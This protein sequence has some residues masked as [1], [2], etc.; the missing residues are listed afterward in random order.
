MTTVEAQGELLVLDD[1]HLA[2]G[3]RISTVGQD[4]WCRSGR[5]QAAVCGR[6]T[7]RRPAVPPASCRF[8]VGSSIA[9]SVSERPSYRAS[10][11]RCQGQSASTPARGV[12]RIV[13]SN[14]FHR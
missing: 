2:E 13:A 3:P 8:P 9:A 5:R 4:A 11:S 12:R 10:T 1:V 6:G 14:D 7:P